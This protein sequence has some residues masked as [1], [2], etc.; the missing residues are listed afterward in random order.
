LLADPE[1]TEREAK[2][3]GRIG[4]HPNVVSLYDFEIGSDGS[5]E[6]MIFEYL[7]GGT[8]TAYLKQA[9]RQSLDDVLRFGRQ[10]LPGAVAPP[11]AGTDSTVTC[12]PTT[13]GLTNGMSLTLATLTRQS[14]RSAPMS[15]GR[16]P[17][18]RI[19]APE[20]RQGGSLDERSDLFSLGGVLHV[21]AN[22]RPLAWGSH[23]AQIAGGPDLPLALGDLIASLLSES[24]DDRPPSAATVL[25]RL[26]EIRHASNIDAL[27][28]AGEGEQIEFKSSLHH[29]LWATIS[30]PA[31]AAGQAGR[32][33]SSEDAQ[34][35]HH[36]D[37]RPHS[38]TAAAARS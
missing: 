25:A 23:A 7:G 34:E 26:D 29:P 21:I 36:Q 2:V 1:G 15:S 38:S 28:A 24:P 32:E 4:N 37:D 5:A 9:D 30:R 11:W 17:R 18:A 14:P 31:E 27:I 6:Y 8:L 19:A 20:E 35:E 3:L 12:H 10:L 22:R 33:G 16:S 13:S